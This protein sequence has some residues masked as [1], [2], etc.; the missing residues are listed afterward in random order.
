MIGWI[1]HFAKNENLGRGVFEKANHIANTQEGQELANYRPQKKRFSIPKFFPGFILNKYSMA[2]YNFLRFAKFS[3]D[4]KKEIVNFDGFFHPLDRLGNWNRLYGKNGFFQYQF[5]IPETEKVADNLI[6]ILSFIQKK[7]LFSFLAVIKYH[8]NSNGIMS[9]PIK[10]YSIALD[11]PNN[12]K[13]LQLLKDLNI[14]IS[15]LNGRVY[16]AKDSTLDKNMFKKMYSNNLK[17]WQDIIKE[18]DKENRI[19]SS[20]SERLN[21]KDYE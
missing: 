17:I 5:I 9:F 12:K 6:D 20:M 16:L 13:T 11:F 15:D 8:K 1:D 18:L 3:F 7:G 21:F 10:G 4:W 14:K 2:I 19:N